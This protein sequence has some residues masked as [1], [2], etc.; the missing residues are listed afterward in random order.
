MGQD[1]RAVVAVPVLV[2]PEG[3]AISAAN[4]ATVL[5]NAYRLRGFT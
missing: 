1:R 5:V 2:A 4:I 3:A